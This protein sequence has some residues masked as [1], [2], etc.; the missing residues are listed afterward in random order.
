MANRVSG[1]VLK[2]TSSLFN[3]ETLSDVSVQFED[4]TVYVN[5]AILASASTVFH[6]MFYGSLKQSS[7]LVV[8]TDPAASY[9]AF[10]AF[11]R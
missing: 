4:K 2:N 5:K 7:Q 10:V 3:N 11:L 8:L 6:A 9:D 1:F